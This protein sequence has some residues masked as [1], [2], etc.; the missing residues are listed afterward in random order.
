MS[1]R[2][3]N[4]DKNKELITDETVKQNLWCNCYMCKLGREGKC[5][6]GDRYNERMQQM[7]EGKHPNGGCTDFLVDEN[8]PEALEYIVAYL[9]REFRHGEPTFETNSYPTAGAIWGAMNYCI[10]CYKEQHS[11]GKNNE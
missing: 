6:W 9:E 11:E 5:T 3:L 4:F 2:D 7:K 10:K 8:S 1:S